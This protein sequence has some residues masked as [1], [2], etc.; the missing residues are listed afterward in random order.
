MFAGARAK[1]AWT[2]LKVSDGIMKAQ[3]IVMTAR[4]IASNIIAVLKAETMSNGAT[5][6]IRHGMQHRQDALCRCL[7]PAY[8]PMDE[9]HREMSGCT[10]GTMFSS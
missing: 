7:W 3:A 4:V 8:S 2:T 5:V 1:H 6:A 9:R 10:C